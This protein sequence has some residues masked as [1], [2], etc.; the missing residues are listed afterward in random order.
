MDL[1]PLNV[2]PFTPAAN[3]LLAGG[4]LCS[5]HLGSPSL[6]LL[7]GNG[8]L[9]TFAGPRI[10]L[11]ALAAHGQTLAVANAAIAADLGQPLDVQSGLAAQVALNGIAVDGVAQLLLVAS[12]RSFTR[13]SGLTPVCARMSLALFLPMP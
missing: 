12:D 9:G 10:G 8:L 2:L 4:C 5:C 13:V 1:A 7:V 6:L 3:D 11:A